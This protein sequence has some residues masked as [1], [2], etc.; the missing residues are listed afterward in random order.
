MFFIF[1]ALIISSFALVA[2]N[3]GVQSGSDFN[4]GD[5]FSESNFDSENPAESVK[6]SASQSENPAESVKESEEIAEPTDSKW[7]K[8]TLLYDGSGYSVSKCD[9]Y[10]VNTYP[11]EIVIPKTYNGEPVTSIG[12]HAINSERDLRKTQQKTP[13]NIENSLQMIA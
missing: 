6:E 9:G 10:D 2:C 12:N 1:S 3:N 4:G 8:F 7:F 11:T 5:F 13:N